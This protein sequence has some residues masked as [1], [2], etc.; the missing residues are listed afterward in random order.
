MTHRE[1]SADMTAA[2]TA[3]RLGDGLLLIAMIAVASLLV[4]VP[5]LVRF[6]EPSKQADGVLR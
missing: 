2:V 5:L 3:P 1:A 4:W 6:A